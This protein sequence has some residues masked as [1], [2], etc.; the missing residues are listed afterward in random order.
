MN[1]QLNFRPYIAIFLGEG[2]HQGYGRLRYFCLRYFGVATVILRGEGGHQ[3][4]GRLRYF[5]LRYFGGATVFLRGEGV[6]RLW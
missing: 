5:C 1:F 2:D 4:Y 3:G 6:A